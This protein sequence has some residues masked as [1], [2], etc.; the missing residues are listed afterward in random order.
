MTTAA[1]TDRL[2]GLS[3]QE[4]FALAVAA[5]GVPA[6][7]PLSVTP[8]AEGLGF[9]S[10]FEPSAREAC[11]HAF[12]AVAALGLGPAGGAYFYAPSHLRAVEGPS[13]GLGAA[14]ALLRA[15]GTLPLGPRLWASGEVTPY[16]A[17]LPVGGLAVK[18][19]LAEARRGRVVLPAGSG[20]PAGLDAAEVADLREALSWLKS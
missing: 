20:A 9:S 6:A 18:L 19:D 1:P 13:L 10:N 15:A 12:A 7:V 17:V 16:G 2:R 8:R 11:A 4:V 3:F 14:L 5:G